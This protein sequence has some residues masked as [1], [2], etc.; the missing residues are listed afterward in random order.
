MGQIQDI[1][2]PKPKELKLEVQTMPT[3]RERTYNEDYSNAM[4]SAVSFVHQGSFSC[5]K[6]DKYGQT[7]RREQS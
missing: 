4:T 7:L 2:E 5:Q 3:V 1:L 6:E